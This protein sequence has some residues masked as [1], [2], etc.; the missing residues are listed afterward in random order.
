M[1]RVACRVSVSNASARASP[2]EVQQSHSGRND[3]GGRHLHERGER[4]VEPDAVPPAH[5]DQVAEPHVGQLVV[6][7]VGHA[8]QLLLRG[9]LRVHQQ[10][11]LPEGDAA[12]VLHR[13]EGEV[14][15]G[16]E[17]DLVARGRA[18]RSSARGTC[19]P[20]SATSSANAH[21]WA[22]PGGCTMRSGIGPA[23]PA[24]RWTSVASSGPTTN[25]TR[26][27]DIGMV[28]AK[29]MRTRPSSVPARSTS[30]ALETARSPLST[31]S[32]MAKVAFMSGSSKQ[33][34]ALRAW[35]DSN[36]VTARA[37]VAP[38]SVEGG[39]VEPDQLVVEG[40]VERQVDLGRAR[41]QGPVEVQ[42]DPLE[43]GVVGHRCVQLH[44]TAADA[45]PRRCPGPGR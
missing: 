25:A 15:H 31:T 19:S 4:L 30:A 5:G 23:V 12:Q 22:L 8:L 35:V 14:G 3:V 43:S 26:Y 16:D 7:H 44:P 11:H 9:A 32:V 17:V 39:P 38:S 13:S 20:A 1:G 18:G 29:R 27:V 40:P 28:S 41:R 34:K 6:D 42:C 24:T 10:Q 36:W 37:V 33:G 2:N 21:R 45:G